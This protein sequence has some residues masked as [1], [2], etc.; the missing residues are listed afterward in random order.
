MGRGRGRTH[1]AEYVFNLVDDPGES[2]NL[3]GTADLEVDW[4]RLKLRAWT[5][6]WQA[7][8]PPTDETLPDEA[9]RRQLE[10]LGY[11]D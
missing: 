2:S 3:A 10:A 7:R 4:L 9:T 8:Q 5:D 6:A 11:T 1:D